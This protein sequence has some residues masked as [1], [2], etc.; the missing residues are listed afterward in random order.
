MAAAEPSPR[1]T[2]EP[3]RPAFGWKD[4]RNKLVKKNI[5]I[6]DLYQN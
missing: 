4:E 6:Y 3:I 1:T 2:V 5:I